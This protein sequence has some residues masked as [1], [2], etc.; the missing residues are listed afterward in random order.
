M[1]GIVRVRVCVGGSPDLHT[2]LQCTRVGKKGQFK[3]KIFLR[4]HNI[5]QDISRFSQDFVW[6]IST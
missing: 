2:G 1:R 6:K 4:N 3:H 5:S